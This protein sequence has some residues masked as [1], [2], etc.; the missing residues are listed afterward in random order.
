MKLISKILITV[1]CF[2]SIAVAN[3]DMESNTIVKTKNIK[4][5]ILIWNLIN[6]SGCCKLAGQ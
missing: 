5:D 2:V 4:V 1:F 3:T 6:I